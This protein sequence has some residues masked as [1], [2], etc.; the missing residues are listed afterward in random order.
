[1]KPLKFSPDVDKKLKEIQ[2]VNVNLY[3]RIQ[4]QLY[5][6]INDPR[7]KSL[8]LHKI[9]RR[10]NLNIWSISINKS[11]RI[12]YEENETIYFFNIGTH[13]EVYRKK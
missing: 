10:D 7:H 11:Y 9:K 4:K 1:M 13:D 2:R 8:R 6:F 3:N 12:L 5:L